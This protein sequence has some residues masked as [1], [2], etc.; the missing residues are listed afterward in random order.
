MTVKEASSAVKVDSYLIMR[1]EKII[2]KD[3]NRFRFAN[4][5]QF[6][7]VAVSQLLNSMEKKNDK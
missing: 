4:K 3:E 5:K 7:D 1:I 2:K 6:V